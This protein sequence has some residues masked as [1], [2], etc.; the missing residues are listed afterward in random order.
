MKHFIWFLALANS[1]LSEQ[2]LCRFPEKN[3]KFLLKRQSWFGVSRFQ[4]TWKMIYNCRSL[5]GVQNSNES[6]SSLQNLSDFLYF[7]WM[8]IMKSI[9]QQIIQVISLNLFHFFNLSKNWKIPLVGFSKNSFLLVVLIETTII[10]LFLRL[11]AKIFLFIFSRIRH[12]FT[13]IKIWYFPF[14]K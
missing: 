4:T 14:V 13:I 7:M 12:H 11:V 10:F 1:I 9:E 8:N 2:H 3:Y 6:L 5:W